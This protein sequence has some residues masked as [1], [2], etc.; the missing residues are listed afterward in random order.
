MA[1]DRIPKSQREDDLRAMTHTDSG[2]K[3]IMRLYKLL[4]EI[5]TG[6]IARPPDLYIG[7]PYGDMIREIIEAEYSADSQ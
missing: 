6:T 3:E 1:D 2:R 5:P 4:S 7:K